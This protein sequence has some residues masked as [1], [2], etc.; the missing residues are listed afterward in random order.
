MSLPRAVLA[1]EEKAEQALQQLKASRE[2]P[3]SEVEQP[4]M[5]SSQEAQQE[6]MQTEEVHAHSDAEPAEQVEQTYEAP[7]ST[8]EDQKWE[9]RYKSL[10]GKY[11]AE[12]P[13][14]AAANKELQAQLQR[15]QKQMEELKTAKPKES[16]IKPEELQE[17]GEPLVDLIRRAA[18][19]EITA[20]DAEINELRNRL[21]GFEVTASK[22]VELGFFEKLNAMVPDW[23]EI[24]EDKEFHSWLDQYDDLAGRRRQDLL[25]DAEGAKDATRVANFFNAWKKTQAI[26]KVTANRNLES[27]VVPSST[28]TN[29]KPPGKKIWTRSE[30]AEFYQRAR[31]GEIDPK[32]MVAIEADIHAAQLE[33]RIR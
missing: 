12:V 10:N 26:R 1:A 13:R 24:N 8:E 16:L 29:T 19:E 3:Q 32:Q 22:S 7:P 25:A 27:Q 9:A 33:K 6:D 23:M 28:Q 2:A 11:Q 4:Q 17:Y 30:I 20:K 14:L 18:R 5:E 15:L 21:E 31:S